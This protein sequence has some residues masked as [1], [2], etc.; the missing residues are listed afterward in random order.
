MNGKA[1]L[2]Y[3]PLATDDHCRFGTRERLR[4]VEEKAGGRLRIELHAL[5][6][7]ILFAPDGGAAGV[8]YRKGRHLYRASP[9]SATAEAGG[10][11]GHDRRPGAR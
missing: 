11:T 1:G 4:E 3:A 10:E 8:E 9:L 6:T 2:C 7:R 5:V